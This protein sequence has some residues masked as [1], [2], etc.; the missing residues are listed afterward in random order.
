MTMPEQHLH[1]LRDITMTDAERDELRRRLRAYAVANPSARSLPVR[2]WQ[3][4]LRHSALALGFALLF[5][6]GGTTVSAERSRPGDVLYGFRLSVNDRIETALAFSDDGQ[7]D[8][9]ME[10][11]Q[12]MIDDEDAVR[13]DELT[14]LAFEAASQPGA[15]LE[16]EFERELREIERELGEQFLLEDPFG[17]TA[18][19]EGVSDTGEIR[20][21]T[22][23]Q[24]P[25]TFDTEDI[26]QELRNIEREL[27]EEERSRLELE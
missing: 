1:N 10:H 12:R 21:R 19:D 15:D 18:D 14:D 3:W 7:I 13:D 9:E 8:V 11:L 25:D 26:E 23:S 2:T 5:I 16:D 24:T 6:A 17:D 20:D 22:P 27:D 4:A